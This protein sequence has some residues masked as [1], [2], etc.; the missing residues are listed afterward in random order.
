MS[1]LQNRPRREKED[2]KPLSFDFSNFKFNKGIAIRSAAILVVGLF[3]IW[4]L[5]Q[6]GSEYDKL[7]D[8][9]R[10]ENLVQD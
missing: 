8:R 5:N 1:R 4:L 9:Y 2:K 6:S 3:V 7:I 10:I